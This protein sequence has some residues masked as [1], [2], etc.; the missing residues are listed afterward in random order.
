MPCDIDIIKP[1]LTACPTDILL[2]TSTTTVRASWIAPTATDNCSTPVITTTNAPG[3]YFSVGLTT[4]T[5]TAT[6]A[7]G[8]KSTCSFNVNVVY[9]APCDGDVTPPVFADCPVNITLTTKGTTAIATWEHP[10]V[11][12]NCTSIPTIQYSHEPGTNFPVGVTTVTYTAKDA[13]GNTSMCTFTITVKYS[14][15]GARVASTVSAD[16][17]TEIAEPI[18]LYP[19]PVNS[20][21]EVTIT[22]APSLFKTNSTIQVVIVGS[23]GITYFT[24]SVTDSSQNSIT[25]PIQNLES[26]IYYVNLLLQDGSAVVRKLLVSK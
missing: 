6:D 10:S 20:Q 8:N 23:D 4:V 2:K 16:T 24:K 13:K 21:K 19:N 11:K 15:T 14:A 26:G 17:T 5:Y 12:D 25:M 1:V 18:V 9:L 22:I 7:N 3:S